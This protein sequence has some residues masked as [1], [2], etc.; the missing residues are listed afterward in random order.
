[1]QHAGNS[2]EQKINIRSRCWV[3]LATS[4]W[5]IDGAV[6]ATWQSGRWRT[7]ASQ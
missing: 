6:I 5:T 4:T 3:V 1:M 2:I 7:E